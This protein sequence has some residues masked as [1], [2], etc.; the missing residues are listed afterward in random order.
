MSTVEAHAQADQAED[1]FIQFRG[2]KKHFG[3]K[4]VYENLALDIRRGESLTIIGGSGQGKSVML[5]MLIGLL[6][7]DAGSI[8]FDGEELTVKREREFA[9]VR[10]RIGMLFQGAALFDSLTVRENVAYGL[11]EHLHMSEQEIST[12]VSDS[13]QNVG[14]TGIEQMWPSDL[15]G[16]MKK[17]VGLARAIAMRPEVLLY[18]EPTTGLDPINTTRI[19]RLIIKLKETLQMTSIVV[20]HDMHSA[21]AISDRIAMVH[22][23]QIIFKGTPQA[24]KKEQD[25][26]IRNFVVGFADD[27]EPLE[28]LMR[29]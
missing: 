22:Q 27:D 28:E 29:S 25:P 5:K 23:G 14:L 6:R 10:K 2:V 13:L 16:G 18:D 12:R 21:Y 1:G 4:R 19:N 17:R 15:S 9:T 7:P 11:R 20:T 3:P 8:H 24:L 26:L